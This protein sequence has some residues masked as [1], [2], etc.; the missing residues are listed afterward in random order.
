MD[1]AGRAEP[2][3]AASGDT[4]EAASDVLELV[5]AVHRLVRS[6]RRASSNRGYSSTQLVVLTHLKDVGSAR[7]GE[8]AA[9]VPCSQP[10]ATTVVKGLQGLGLVER[11]P[12]EGDRR[13]TLVTITKLGLAAVRAVAES[14]ASALARRL[15][16]LDDDERER[17]RELIPLLTA[18]ADA[19]GED[20]R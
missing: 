11:V 12:D 20:V 5:I 2:G 15:D 19:P 17:V 7:I 14:R 6:L 3:A 9:H 18:L 13:A 16:S 1:A 8:I 10:T 4:G